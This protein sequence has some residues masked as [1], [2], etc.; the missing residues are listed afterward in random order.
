[1][2]LEAGKSENKLFSFVRGIPLFL[3][4]LTFSIS[5][6]KGLIS[7]NFRDTIEKSTRSS[8]GEST[9]S[10]FSVEFVAGAMASEKTV[11]LLTTFPPSA[12]SENPGSGFVLLVRKSKALFLVK[13]KQYNRL[14][15]A[16]YMRDRKADFLFPF[17]YFW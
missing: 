17:H 7:V 5:T 10:P 8:A 3:F 12:A 15:R 13:F 1:M 16:C 14:F 11:N 2:R 6:S 4:L 9:L